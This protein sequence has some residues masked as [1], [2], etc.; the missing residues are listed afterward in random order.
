MPVQVR[1]PAPVYAAQRRR[2]P[3][4]SYFSEAGLPGTARL[5]LG[6]PRPRRSQFGEGGLVA[7]SYALASQSARE[8]ATGRCAI[9]LA[10]LQFETTGGLRVYR[11]ALIVELIDFSEA[12]KLG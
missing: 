11:D 10:L 9:Q 6:K 5:R 4:R 1:P 7:A 8:P 3:R 2:L 12:N